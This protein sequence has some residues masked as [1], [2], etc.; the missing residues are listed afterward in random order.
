MSTT[1]PLPSCKTGKTYNIDS[2][3]SWIG[4]GHYVLE[5][6]LVQIHE[7]TGIELIRIKMNMWLL[8]A[9]K[10][11]VHRL[12]V[13]SQ[14]SRQPAGITH[15]IATGCLELGQGIVVA[16]S[17]DGIDFIAREFRGEGTHRQT[18]TRQFALDLKCQS[19]EFGYSFHRKLVCFTFDI[20][21]FR[22]LFWTVKH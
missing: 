15:K 18:K 8:S 17:H 13:Q 22:S 14:C 9:I 7:T 6:A 4:H 20:A 21:R 16:Q 12:K 11:P 1:L 5:R 10:E 19:G 3:Q 2:G